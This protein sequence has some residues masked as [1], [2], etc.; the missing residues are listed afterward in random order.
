MKNQFSFTV[1]FF[2]CIVVSALA[3]TNTFPVTGNAGIGTLNPAHELTVE[4]S[5][6]PNIEL[7]NSN[8]SNGGF[9]INRTNYGQQ[10]KWWAE[11][12]VMYLGFATNEINFSNKLT[13][14]S[15]GNVGI[16]ITNPETLLHVNGKLSIGKFDSTNTEGFSID[17]LDGGTAETT[18]KHRRWGANIYFKR[19]G[20]SGERKQ[21]YFGGSNNHRMYIYDDSDQVKVRLD[22]GGESYFNGGNVGIGVTSPTNPLD[23]EGRI[24]AGKSRV[25]QLDWTYETNWGGSSNKWAGYIGFN[26]YRNNDDTKDHFYGKNKYTHKGVIEGS[27]YGFRWLYRKG[28]GSDSDG[29]HLLNEYMRLDQDG[30]LGLGTSN[31]D[32]KLTVKGKIHA[33]EV[34]VDLSVPGPDYVFANDYKLTSLEQLQQYININKHLPNIPS[35]KEMEAN[36][37]D[38]GVMNMKLLEKI[39]ELTLYTL[40]QQQ[41]INKLLQAVKELKSN[42]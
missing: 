10:W 31:P 40:K 38:L 7:K 42:K 18:F 41:Q 39:E 2:L 20:S 11:N 28:V 5:S 17:Y 13:I 9:I 15:N 3:Q 16:G 8:Y 30:N 26:A 29:Q 32:S 1:C 12:N 27:N 35:A 4:G 37:I 24:G 23:V 22:S 14:E 19:G 36:G 33:E 25:L 21:F 34:K 6:S